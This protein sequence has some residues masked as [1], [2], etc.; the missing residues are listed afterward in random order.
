MFHYLDRRHR[1]TDKDFGPH[2][3][4]LDV[5]PEKLQRLRGEVKTAMPDNVTIP[6]FRQ[7][8]GL[9]NFHIWLQS[10]TKDFVYTAESSLG[11]SA[12]LE[13]RSNS[14]RPALQ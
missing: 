13:N 7:L 11:A 5:N 3:V 1:V 12:S 2:H 9:R 10:S 14:R 6:I 4:P 8:Q